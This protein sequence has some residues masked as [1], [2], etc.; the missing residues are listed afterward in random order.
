[1]IFDPMRE[2]IEGVRDRI[3]HA[4][5]VGF[6]A[7]ALVVLALVKVALMAAERF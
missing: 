1:M 2:G 3:I 4:F 5:V 6:A 7:G